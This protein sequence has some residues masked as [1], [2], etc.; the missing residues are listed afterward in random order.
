[1]TKLISCSQCRHFIKDQIGD[2]MGIGKCKLF[3]DYC[4]KNPSD[5]AKRQAL[6]KLGDRAGIGIFWGGSGSR[7]CGRFIDDL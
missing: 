5:L 3:E 6:Y 1:M 4:A 7:E 2:G